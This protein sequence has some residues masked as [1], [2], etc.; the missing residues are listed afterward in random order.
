MPS[1]NL[2]KKLLFNQLK[3]W[4]RTF[5]TLRH[6]KP[7]QTWYFFLRRG[8][9]ARRVNSFVG[10]IICRKTSIHP[11]LQL[12]HADGNFSV[13]EFDFLNHTLSFPRDAMN[14]CPREALRLWRY[15][16]HYF[17]FLRDPTRPLQ[18][19]TALINDWI[20]NNPQGS[21]P[22]WEP[23]TASLRI[24]NWCLFFWS[25]PQEKIAE[26][27]LQSLYTQA[28]WLE[29][30][31]ELHILANHYF[32]N[33]KAMLFASLFFNN[34]DSTRWLHRFQ[35]ELVAQLREQTLPDGGHYERSP[36]YHCILLEDY[37]DIYALLRTDTVL[38]ETGTFTVLEQTIN[39]GLHFLAGIATP[40]DDIPLFNDSASGSASRPSVLFSKAEQ[41]GFKIEIPRTALI[42]FPDSGLFGWKSDSDYFLIDCGDIGPAYQPG[43]THCDFLSFVLMIDG[44]W[45]IVDSGV[46]EYEPGAMR[47][48][49]RSTAAHNTVTVD[50][51]E[52]SEIW[53]EFRVGRRARSRGAAIR[54][55]ANSIIFEG[56]YEGFASLAAKIVHSR[57]AVLTLNT[58]GGIQ[59]V[60]IDDTVEGINKLS[61]EIKASL[62]LHPDWRVDQADNTTSHEKSILVG[63]HG[64]T[65]VTLSSPQGLSSPTEPSWFCPEFGLKL[66]NITLQIRSHSKLPAHA[67]CKLALNH[68]N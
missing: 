25:L 19:K 41:L 8:I 22:A 54:R 57:R 55:E 30:N 60:E 24:V 3:R 1:I 56:A 35:K 42:N 4:W 17:D 27:W 33:I 46:C 65:L 67:S 61:H 44:Q 50:D 43:H 20:A 26:Q 52:Q 58:Q 14:W 36:Q 31:L 38:I 16:L 6:L 51:S 2:R 28:R 21:E 32:E 40:D 34:H 5:N 29:R 64:G 47:S 7:R 59:C 11:V 48:Y 9:G 45:L 18:Q 63:K 66:P 39:S 62:H 23:Y 37:L 49:V 53:S 12:S 13:Y 15:N 10:D 68:P